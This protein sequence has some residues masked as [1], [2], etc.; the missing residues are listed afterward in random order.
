MEGIDPGVVFKG[1]TKRKVR[2]MNSC[3]LD[4]DRELSRDAEAKP[5]D[6]L[7]SQGAQRELLSRVLG[8]GSAAQARLSW[9]GKNLAMPEGG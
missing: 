5:G 4:P 1:G 7:Q 3:G 9:Q 2:E 8:G 6:S